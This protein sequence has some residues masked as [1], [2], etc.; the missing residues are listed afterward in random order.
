VNDHDI[1]VINSMVDEIGI[2]ADRKHPNAANVGLA[3]KP[4]ISRN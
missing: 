3:A 1:V 4:W 2:A